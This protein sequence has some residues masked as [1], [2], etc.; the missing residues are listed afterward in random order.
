MKPLHEVS[1]SL[2][3]GTAGASPQIQTRTS[4]EFGTRPSEIRSSEFLP[5]LAEATGPQSLWTCFA[6]FQAL[7]SERGVA[8]AEIMVQTCANFQLRIRSVPIS[9]HDTEVTMTQ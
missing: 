6:L 5:G 2:T 3:E 1:T 8:C 9:H 7:A 4:A